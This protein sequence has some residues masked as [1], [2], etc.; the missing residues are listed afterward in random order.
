MQSGGSALLSLL[1]HGHGGNELLRAFEAVSPTLPST[2]PRPPPSSR[3]GPGL[4][5]VTTVMARWAAA[6]LPHIVDVVGG[7]PARWCHWQSVQALTRSGC[8]SVESLSTLA[9]LSCAL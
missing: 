7:P 2:Y 1:R 6:A 5:T 9:V 8:T 3:C 4:G